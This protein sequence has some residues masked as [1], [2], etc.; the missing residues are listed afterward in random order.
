[1]QFR[2]EPMNDK[3]RGRYPGIVYNCCIL[4]AVVCGGMLAVWKFA[5]VIRTI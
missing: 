4:N 3:Y 1:M 2:K 5:W